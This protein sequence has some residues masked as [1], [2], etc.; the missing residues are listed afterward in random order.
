MY[1][2]YASAAGW[3]KARLRWAD[4]SLVLFAGVK[5][6]GTIA[7]QSFLKQLNSK[8][9]MSCLQDVVGSEPHMKVVLEA[10]R[11]SELTRRCLRG[12]CTR[13]S[14]CRQSAQASTPHDK[15]PCLMHP[16]SHT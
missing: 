1:H 12:P 13:M 4:M 7:G 8:R 5:L 16:D 14:S 3:P 11:K 2:C 15:D 9:H 10:A 6:P